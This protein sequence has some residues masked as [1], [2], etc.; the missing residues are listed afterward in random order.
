MLCEKLV[1]RRGASR[2]GGFESSSRLGLNP[3]FS[4]RAGSSP[5][6]GIAPSSSP[7]SSND[8]SGR[9]LMLSTMPSAWGPS[10]G[11][12]GGDVGAVGGTVWALFVPAGARSGAVWVV[13]LMLIERASHGSPDRQDFRR[14]LS[15]P[16]LEEGRTLGDAARGHW[17]FPRLDIARFFHDLGHHRARPTGGVVVAVWRSERIGEHLIDASQSR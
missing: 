12:L 10:G 16:L 4:T 9:C 8:P 11:P 3:A 2:G 15:S 17:L 5:R 6:R 7:A 14:S 13:I 1:P